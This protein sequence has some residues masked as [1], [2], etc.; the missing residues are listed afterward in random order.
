MKL[1]EHIKQCL[2]LLAAHGDLTVAVNDLACGYHPPMVCVGSTP[3]TLSKGNQV[4]NHAIIE[5]NLP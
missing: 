2:D 4:V 5:A 1:S 3:T